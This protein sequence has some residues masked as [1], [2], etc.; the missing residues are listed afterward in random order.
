MLQALLSERFAL[1]VHFEKKNMAVYELRVAKGGPKF[2]ESQAPSAES[3]GDL[4]RPPAAGPP[5]PTMA[6]VVR[7][8]A[9][10]AD[11]A[12]F[13][14]DQ[15]GRPVHDATGLRKRYDYSLTFL[16]EPGGRA[17]GP[18]T[19][20]ELKPEFGMSLIDAVREQLGLSLQAAKGQV[21]VL[22]VDHADR[23]PAAN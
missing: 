1:R 7:K 19:S 6:H 4:W 22:I 10:I 16:M 13:L 12:N 2:A 17:A 5:R 20:S 9:S 18:Q 21:D 8:G 14:A 23:S 15:L 3:S 11:L